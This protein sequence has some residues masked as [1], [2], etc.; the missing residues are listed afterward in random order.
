M[1]RAPYERFIRFADVEAAGFVFFANYLGLC[2]EAY[3]ASLL[4][5]GIE[6]RAFFVANQTLLPIARTQAQY[7]GPLQSGNKVRVEIAPT[8]VSDST[9]RIDYKVF[10]AGEQDKLVALAQTEHAA[11]DLATLARKPLPADLVRWLESGS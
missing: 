1:S 10:H 7:L 5:S 11:I 8:R 2:H 3:E 9:F 6:L 4:R